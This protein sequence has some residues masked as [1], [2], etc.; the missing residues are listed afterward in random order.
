LFPVVSVAG[1]LTDM[2]SAF[3]GI[4][5]AIFMAVK[6]VKNWPTLA[7]H[8]QRSQALVPTD[9]F[10]FEKPAVFVQYLTKKPLS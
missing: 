5:T 10:S 9:A 4:V 1:G 7:S 3:S 6:R 2:G 8:G